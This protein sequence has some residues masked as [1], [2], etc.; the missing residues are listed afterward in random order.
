LDERFE[1]RPLAPLVQVANPHA[2]LSANGVKRR[3]GDASPLDFADKTLI[4]PVQGFL[5]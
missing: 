1:V 4:E 3:D 2:G 5:R